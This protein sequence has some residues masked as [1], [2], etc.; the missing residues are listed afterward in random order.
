M[1]DPISAA[2]PLV[3][4]P[5]FTFGIIL[6]ENLKT[7]TT[8]LDDLQRAADRVNSTFLYEMLHF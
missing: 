3:A 8:T 5:V 1:D 4:A 6:A 2:S 7:L